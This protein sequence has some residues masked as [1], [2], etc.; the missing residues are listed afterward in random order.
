M[1]QIDVA[2]IGAGPAG[3]AAA[4]TAA[5][6]GLAVTLLDSVAVPG[7]RIGDSLPGAAARVLREI[8][9]W[10]RFARAGHLPA[11]LKVSRWGADEAVALDAFRDPDGAGWCLDRPRF[12]ADL[13]DGAR[14]RGV[15]LHSPVTVRGYRREADGWELTCG[16]GSVIRAGFVIDCGGARSGFLRRE[17][18][19]VVLDRLAC[20]Y[21]RVRSR[22]EQ[23]RT[24]YTQAVPDGW[25]YT[26]PLPGRG[27]IVAFHTDRDL[28][29]LRD[30]RQRGPA[31]VASSLPG[32]GG[33]VDG[34]PEAAVRV[35]TAYTVAR[36]GAGAGWV[37]AGDSAISLDPL[38]SQGMFNALVTGVDAGRTAGAVLAGE[39]DAVAGYG[40]RLGRIWQAYLRHHGMYYGMERRWAAAPF[41]SRRVPVRGSAG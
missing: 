5:G 36:S 25:W 12:E 4:L 34:E 3:C 33:L 17:R 13:R 35:G 41:W 6:A 16:D 26:A 31:R 10:E 27:R 30:V 28:P 8:G 32:L 40:E 29:A 11:P 23:D 24:I 1:P 21:Q 14:E 7:W 9:A 2:V 38:S 20:V 37:A 22:P 39:D 19:R 18:G 15:R